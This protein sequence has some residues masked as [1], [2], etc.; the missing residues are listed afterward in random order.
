MNSENIIQT[1]RSFREMVASM[2][3]VVNELAG[4]EQERFQALGEKIETATRFNPK[5]EG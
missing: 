1:A 4:A 2:G 3:A 5:F